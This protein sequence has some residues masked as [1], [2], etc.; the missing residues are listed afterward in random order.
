MKEQSSAVYVSS[1]SAK[2]STQQEAVNAAD[3]MNERTSEGA[4][5]IE[6]MNCS[7]GPKPKSLISPKNSLPQGRGGSCISG[8]HSLLWVGPEFSYIS[9]KLP[10]SKKSSRTFRR[11]PTESLFHLTSSQIHQGSPR[12]LVPEK[13]TP[14][15]ASNFQNS[16]PQ[17]YLQ[18][19]M[20][21]GVSFDL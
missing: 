18:L 19:R 7:V 16:G 10:N 9:C 8:Y 1:I 11:N 5:Q 21:A 4:K 3:G 20:P 6:T 13:Y 2:P 17:S 14:R 15:F 12:I